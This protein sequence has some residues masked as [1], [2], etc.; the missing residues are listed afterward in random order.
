MWNHR[1]IDDPL[2]KKIEEIIHSFIPN[3]DYGLRRQNPTA[4]IEK[5]GY[6]ARVM[7]IE[8]RFLF[9]MK[10]DEIVEAWRS[11]NTLF[12]QSKGQFNEIVGAI[13]K[14]LTAEE[15]L[16]PY[17]TRIWFANFIADKDFLARR[18]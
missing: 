4:M 9:P 6:F 12:R 14:E 11:H 10:K 5:S 15:Y 2:Q 1:D 8:D 7:N 3:Y 13:S 16:V 18:V 17:F